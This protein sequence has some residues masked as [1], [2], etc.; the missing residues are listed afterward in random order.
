MW[1]QQIQDHARASPVSDAQC[2]RR[3]AVS[4]GLWLPY[5]ERIRL[6]KIAQRRRGRRNKETKRK[7]VIG[8]LNVGAMT[9]RRREVVDQMQRKAMDILCVQETRWKGEKAREMGDGYKLYYVG[10][11]GKKNGVGVLLSPEMEDNV[12]EVKREPDRLIWMRMN[13][14]KIELNIVSAYAP[15]SRIL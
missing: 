13:V 15:P 7:V 3:D 2:D 1:N 5:Q 8:T 12:L 11:D 9:G 4:N 14:G 6:K 10:G